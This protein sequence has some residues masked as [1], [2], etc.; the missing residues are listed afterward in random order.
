MFSSQP[1]RCSRQGGRTARGRAP[2]IAT[3]EG[4]DETAKALLSATTIFWPH[5]IRPSDKTAGGERRNG[6]DGNNQPG[7]PP[8]SGRQWPVGQQAAV[9]GSGMAWPST[10]TAPPQR[11]ALLWVGGGE[12]VGCPAVCGDFCE[13]AR[14]QWCATVVRYSGVLLWRVRWSPLEPAGA[15]VL[16]VDWPLT[17]AE[18][19]LLA[20]KACCSMFGLHQ[21]DSPGPSSLLVCF[22][23]ASAEASI[24]PMAQPACLALRTH[25][26]LPQLACWPRPRPGPVLARVLVCRPSPGHGGTTWQFRCAAQPT[27]KM[28]GQD[29]SHCAFAATH[30]P[31]TSV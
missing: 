28:A 24:L 16:A 4:P 29:A 30:H 18:D 15:V 19:S 2:D 6:I 25:P 21:P 1:G 23:L 17:S 20:A 12:Q 22:W 7:W 27:R 8:L 11:R 13:S 5:R 10:V 14:L 9:G 3:G 31:R 26:C